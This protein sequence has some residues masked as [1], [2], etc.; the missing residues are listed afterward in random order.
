MVGALT[1]CVL[2]AVA[3]TVTVL[4]GAST[5]LFTDVMV[6]VPVLAVAPAAMVSVVLADSVK[7]PDT[8]GD[9]AVADT[10]MVVAAEE[11]R[12]SVAVTVLVSAFSEI[13]DGD[14][15]SVTC[16]GPSSSVMVSG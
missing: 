10:S 7:S 1:P 11:A 4:S 2:L 8:A 14:S 5:A 9:T 15:T 13:E 6:T 16:G 3:D 12:F